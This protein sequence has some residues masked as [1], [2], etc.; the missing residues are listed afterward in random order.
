MSR[1][2]ACACRE[3]PRAPV[4]DPGREGAHSATRE[5]EGSLDDAEAVALASDAT[6]R[7]DDDPAE[8]HARDIGG[9]HRHRA[10]A[11]QGRDGCDARDEE[12]RQ[13]PRT[14]EI[15]GLRRPI[16]R[17]QERHDDLVA[18]AAIDDPLLADETVM[19]DFARGAFEERSVAIERARC[20]A[21][22][23][24]AQVRAV[25]PLGEH[26]RAEGAPPHAV[27]DHALLLLVAIEVDREEAE[28]RLAQGH[29]EAPACIGGNRGEP[30]R[31]YRRQ[32]RRRV[33]RGV[34]GEDGGHSQS[35][36]AFQD[37]LGIGLLLFHGGEERACLRCAEI[38]LNRGEQPGPSCPR[39]AIRIATSRSTLPPPSR[40]LPSSWEAPC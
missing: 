34:L 25:L 16:A 6:R 27:E 20:S 38:L 22:R 37:G 15:G 3:R 10:V 32:P 35:M 2:R 4:R 33:A 5:G 31:V 12:D 18:R 23:G 30:R 40:R 28:A 39:T 24:P 7:W 13:F 17:A 11:A 1:S 19:G 9:P 14:T 29:G 21:R 36:E 8:R 26:E